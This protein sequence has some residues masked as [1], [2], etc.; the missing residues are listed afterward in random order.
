MFDI[1]QTSLAE[2]RS[3]QRSPS[4]D[5]E[6]HMTRVAR[7]E[8]HLGQAARQDPPRPDCVGDPAILSAFEPR[9]MPALQLACPAKDGAAQRYRMPLWRDLKAVRS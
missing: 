9:R 5:I 2:K 8:P 1:A 3:V 4:W 6:I 7:T